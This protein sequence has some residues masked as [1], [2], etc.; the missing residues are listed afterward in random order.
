MLLTMNYIVKRYGVRYTDIITIAY[1]QPRPLNREKLKVSQ[2]RENAWDVYEPNYTRP[3]AIC[4]LSYIDGT[5]HYSITQ[6]GNL[7]T[8]TNRDTRNL[9]SEAHRQVLRS[10]QIGNGDTGWWLNPSTK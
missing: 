9:L 2:V 1:D 8:K 7:N 5:E 4:D 3:I 6:T 10:I